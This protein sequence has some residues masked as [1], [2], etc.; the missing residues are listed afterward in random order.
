[1]CAVRDD[2]SLVVNREPDQDKALDPS[3]PRIRC[4]KC[5]WSPGKENKWL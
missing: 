1:M 2:P 3:G 4:P 5:G